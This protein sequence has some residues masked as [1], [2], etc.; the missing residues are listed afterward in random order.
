MEILR[1][2]EHADWIEN[3]EVQDY[4]QWESGFYYRL[5]IVFRKHVNPASGQLDE[6]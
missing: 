6:H 3:Y 1:L 4:R 5:K 2:L